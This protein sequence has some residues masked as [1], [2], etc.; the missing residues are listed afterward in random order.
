MA[1]KK[2]TT[3]TK[4]QVEDFTALAQALECQANVKEIKDS[5]AGK[6]KEFLDDWEF[7]LREGVKIGNLKLKVKISRQFVAERA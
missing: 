7:Q 3:L 2:L 1:N 6:Y 5:I 4:E